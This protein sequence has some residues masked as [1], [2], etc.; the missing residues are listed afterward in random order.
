[1]PWIAPANATTPGRRT[2]AGS[3]DPA[4]SALPNALSHAQG[5]HRSIGTKCLRHKDP[6]TRNTGYGGLRFV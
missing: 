6:R 5:A 2:A 4:P 3:K 1:M